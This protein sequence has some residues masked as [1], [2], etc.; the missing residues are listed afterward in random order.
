MKNFFKHIFEH[1]EQWTLS[2]SKKGYKCVR[3]ISNI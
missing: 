1:N 3:N 2:V